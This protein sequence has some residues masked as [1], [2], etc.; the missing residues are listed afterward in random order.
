MYKALRE[1]LRSVKPV[2]TRVEWVRFPL[3]PNWK[4]CYMKR[5]TKKN[6]EKLA[7]E[8]VDQMDMEALCESVRDQLEIFYREL[9]NKEFNKEWEQVFGDN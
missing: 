3:H 7:K 8:V 1:A 2:F 9:S 5:N 4:R 6:A